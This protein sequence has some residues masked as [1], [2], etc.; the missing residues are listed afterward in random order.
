MRGAV[1]PVSA[2]EADAYFATRS[3]H[4][5]DRRLGEQAINAAGKPAVLEKAVAVYTAKFGIGSR[6]ASAVLVGL[7]HRADRDRVLADRPFRLHDRIVFRR[8]RRSRAWTKTRLY[9]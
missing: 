3:R 2:A 5:A 1:E 4:A 6:S 9:P 7:S 8:E